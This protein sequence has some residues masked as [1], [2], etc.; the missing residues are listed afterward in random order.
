MG[1][2]AAKNQEDGLKHEWTA[3]LQMQCQ[4]GVFVTATRDK[5]SA[6]TACATKAYSK[7]VAPINRN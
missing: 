3:V 1:K 2:K 7:E 4:L 5:G 6:L